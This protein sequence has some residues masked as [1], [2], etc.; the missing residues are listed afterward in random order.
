[1]VDKTDAVDDTEMFSNVKVADAITEVC[2]IGVK[3]IEEADVAKVLDAT[4]DTDMF[5]AT[6]VA[7]MLELES[8]VV[9]DVVILAGVDID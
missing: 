3:A 4:I 6:V 5:D 1:M 8:R 7:A 2:P 9:V